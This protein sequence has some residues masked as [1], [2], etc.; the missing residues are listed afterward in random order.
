MALTRP[1]QEL[2]RDLK[3]AAALIKWAVHRAAELSEAGLEADAQAL[4]M[5]VDGFPDTED[6][7]A[8]YAEEVKAGQKN[9]S[10]PD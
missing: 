6:K 2:R 8:G 5:L 4:L 9:R 10:K 3:E 7:L 1:N